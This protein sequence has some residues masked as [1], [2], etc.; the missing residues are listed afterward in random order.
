MNCKYC[1]ETMSLEDGIYC[2]DN[3]GHTYDRARGEETQPTVPRNEWSTS[4]PKKRLSAFVGTLR[5]FVFRGWIV[6]LHSCSDGWWVTDRLGHKH[7][8]RIALCK[9][10]APG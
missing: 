10:V 3:C 6:K 9:M 4:K 2:C 5:R 7:Y 8:L 1:E